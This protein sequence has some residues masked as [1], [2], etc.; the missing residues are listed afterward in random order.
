MV[1]VNE[2]GRLA[3]PFI[4]YGLSALDADRALLGGDAGA[5]N[6]GEESLVLSNSLCRPI[7]GTACTTAIRRRTCRQVIKLGS[8]RVQLSSRWR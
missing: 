7:S 6:K 3:N 8:A 1:A 2:L 4:V 5:R